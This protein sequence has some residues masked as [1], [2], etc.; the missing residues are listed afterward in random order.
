MNGDSYD[1]DCGILVIDDH[2]ISRLFTFEALSI[3]TC[4][5]KQVESGIQ[6][7]SIIQDWFPRLIFTDIHLPDTCGLEL[8]QEIRSAWPKGRSLPHIVVITGDSS[9]G[10]MRRTAQ[11]D[12]AGI[13]LKPVQME[14][15]R[16]RAEQL[17]YPGRLVQEKPVTSRAAAIDQKISDLFTRELAAWLPRLD[18]H[19][20]QLDWPP[21]CEILHQL[22]ASSAMC[23]KKEL[24]RSSRFLY[25]AISCDPQP[26]TIAEAYHPFLQAVANVKMRLE[27]RFKPAESDQPSHGQPLPVQQ[28]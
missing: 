21:A 1:H 4:N 27:P 15:I 23:R 12:V 9:A 26:G 10:M 13:L 3:F 25:R 17:I 8:V 14:D 2:P 11:A 22:I 16:T 24:E 7:I 28:K 18:R 5:I 20:S 6:A 19:I